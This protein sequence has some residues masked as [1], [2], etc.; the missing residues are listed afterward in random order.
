MADTLALTAIT[1][2][3]PASTNSN[4]PLSNPSGKRSLVVLG[5]T[6][7]LVIVFFLFIN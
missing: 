7:A 4:L 3:G 5:C 1:I 2:F 6:I